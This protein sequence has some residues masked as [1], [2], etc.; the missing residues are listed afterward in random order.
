M[1]VNVPISKIMSRNIVTVNIEESLKETEKLMLK[2]HI[3]HIP[4]MNESRLIGIVSLTDL[5][6]IGFADAYNNE[7]KSVDNV[8]YELLTLEQV[9]VKSPITIQ[10][11]CSIKEAS[12]ILVD[13]EFHALPILDGEELVGIVTTTDLIRYFI[14]GPDC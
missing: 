10:Q 14:S 12:Q 5:Q 1:L 4:I 11:D 9:M 8:I 7:E 2:N 13:N 6:R 3:R